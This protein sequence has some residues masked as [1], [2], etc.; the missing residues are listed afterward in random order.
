ME[1]VADIQAIMNYLPHRY[2]FLLVDRILEIVPG[3]KIVALKN[4]TMNEPFFQGHFPGTPIMPGVLII[5][6]M[7]Q[8]GG[9]LFSSEQLKEKQGSLF[10]FMGM[11]KVK[12]RKPVVPGDQIIFEVKIIRQ[13]SKVVKMAGIAT[14]DQKIVAEAE[15]MAT[16]GEK[17]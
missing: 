17:T 11:D 5:E 15:L 14:V 2:P 8:A 9:V 1:K 7:A 10:Y 4:V 16:I 6:A 3:E 12:F 13:R